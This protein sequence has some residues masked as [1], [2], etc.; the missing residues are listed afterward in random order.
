MGSSSA[1]ATN[2]RVV[3]IQVTAKG[4]AT[5]RRVGRSAEARILPNC[6]IRWTM[7]QEPGSRLASRCCCAYSPRTRALARMSVRGSRTHAAHADARDYA[8][9]VRSGP[10]SYSGSPNSV[11]GASMKRRTVVILGVV[12]LIGA[13][14]GV[15]RVAP[16]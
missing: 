1:P 16:P 13:A 15:T 11:P 7:R 12:I 8:G 3:R 14:G 10:T 9:T 2:R 4:R 6:S 5:V